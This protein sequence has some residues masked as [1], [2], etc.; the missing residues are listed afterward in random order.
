MCGSK[1]WASRKH[2][3]ICSR[4]CR[5]RRHRENCAGFGVPSKHSDLASRV[6]L[7]SPLRRAIESGDGRAVI[8]EILASTV[9]DGD[10]RLWTGRVKA[11][12]GYAMVS[13]ASRDVPVHRLV[14][15]AKLGVP[16]GV[17][18]AHHMCGVTRCVNPNHLQAVTQ[19]ENT[20]EMLAR[21][22]YEARI[23]ELESVLRAV[24]PEHEVL[25][26]AAA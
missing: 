21:R 1:F 24:A 8:A 19:A 4:S 13:L 25:R 14:L 16:L 5:R 3:E 18:Q 15:E 22:S 6:D 7:R 9:P 26:R 17:L 23:R 20:G 10:C 12:R 11:A 2:A